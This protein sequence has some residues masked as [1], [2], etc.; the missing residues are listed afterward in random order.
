MRD[1][2]SKQN[3][4]REMNHKKITTP[5]R[6]KE[7]TTSIHDAALHL[8]EELGPENVTIEKIA[9]SANVAKTTIYRRWPNAAA[10]I[11]D[12]FLTEI[13]PVISYIPQAKLSETFELALIDFSKA[14]VPSRKDLL[15]H[16]IAAAQS[17]PDLSKAFWDS[18]ISP[19]PICGLYPRI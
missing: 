3:Y 1:V 11:M 2:H 4:G 8:A 17:E 16:L 10:V 12:A 5:L 6:G 14:L 19:G 9:E 18:W 15:L 13:R 7:A